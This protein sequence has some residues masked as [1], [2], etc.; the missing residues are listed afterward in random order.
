MKGAILVHHGY[1]LPAELTGDALEK[2]AHAARPERVY[3]IVTFVEY[4]K[5]GGE[6]QTSATGYGGTGVTGWSTRTDTYTMDAYYPEL[7]ASLAKTVNQKFDAYFFDEDNNIYGINDD[8]DVLA[9]FPMSCVYATSTQ[10]PTSSEKATMTVSFCFE[11]A[12]QAVT[13]Y[14][15]Q[16]LGFDPRKY[17]LGLVLVT[18]GKTDAS[19]SK[20]KL[21]EAL[22]GADITSTYGALIA[23]NAN[24]ISGNA[25]AVSYDEESDTLSITGSTSPSLKAPSV[26]YEAGVIGIEQA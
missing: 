25:T 8:T 11:D 18:L 24:L 22:G 5:D 20:Y 21:Y 10:H 15:Y 1:K 9:G 13:K 4:A 3:G 12:K 17:T 7:D 6:A 16:P 19:G 26:L 2:L 23:D 14:D